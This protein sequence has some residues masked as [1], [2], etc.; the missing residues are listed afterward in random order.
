[1]CYKTPIR[2]FGMPGMAHASPSL[3]LNTVA[4]GHV[5]ITRNAALLVPPG[6]LIQALRVSLHVGQDGSPSGQ[7][8]EAP[9]PPGCRWLSAYR[10]ANG[11]S[12]WIIQEATQPLTTV[13]LPHEYPSL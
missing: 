13:L 6:D 12:F 5:L 9:E 11:V 3:P 1:M 4:G 7:G 8:T 2:L 10:A